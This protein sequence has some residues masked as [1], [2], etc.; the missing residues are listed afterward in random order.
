MRE[1][2]EISEVLAQNDMYLMP[3]DTNY[4]APAFLR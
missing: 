3:L 1:V 4:Y 2:S